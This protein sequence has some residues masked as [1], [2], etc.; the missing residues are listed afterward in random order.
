M[1]R[2]A[3]IDDEK[4]MTLDLKNNLSPFLTEEKTAFQSLKIIIVKHT[5]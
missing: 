2:I 4:E 5:I 1:L 3:I